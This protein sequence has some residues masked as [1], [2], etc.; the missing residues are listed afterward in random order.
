M[1]ALVPQTSAPSSQVIPLLICKRH[2]TAQWKQPS[3]SHASNPH[4]F[5]NRDILDYVLGVRL[6]R[7]PDQTSCTCGAEEAGEVISLSLALLGSGRTSLTMQRHLNM[8][9]TEG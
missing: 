8:S 5:I 2:D 9:E 4:P 3:S 7:K 1:P 6:H